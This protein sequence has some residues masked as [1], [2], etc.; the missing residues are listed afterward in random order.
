MSVPVSLTAF[1]TVTYCVINSLVE[2]PTQTDIRHQAVLALRLPGLSI[3]RDELYSL[4]HDRGRRA[5]TSVQHF[6][7][8][9]RRFL[10]D[11]ECLGCNSSGDVRP[12]AVTIGSG[13]FL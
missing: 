10:G 9:D 7:G 2:F 6:D 13:I 1:P 5:P 8:Q 11:A 12:V 3:F 4:E